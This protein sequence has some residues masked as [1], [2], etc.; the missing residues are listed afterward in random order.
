MFHS[1][2]LECE[3]SGFHAAVAALRSTEAF[4]ID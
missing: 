4:F 2:L 3:L 1:A